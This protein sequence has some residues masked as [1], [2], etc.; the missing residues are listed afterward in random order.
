MIIQITTA[1]VLCAILAL[2]V[3]KQSPEIA[4]IVTIAAT[5]VIFFMLLPMLMEVMG[6]MRHIGTLLD[7]GQPYVALAIK[8]IGVA[9]LAELGASICLDAGESA[10]AAKI[11]LAGR[12]VILILATPVVMDIVNIIIGLMP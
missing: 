1:G 12:V 7:G 5:A 9:Y 2:T 4:L 6:M 8:V 11:E 10:I 3:K